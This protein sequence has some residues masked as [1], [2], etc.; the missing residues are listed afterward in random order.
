MVKAD[1]AQACV[2]KRSIV[3][4]DGGV[5]YASP[6][7]LFQVTGGGFRNLTE[8][9]FTR[10]EWQL[11]NP[12]SLQGFTVGNY[13][14]GFY[15]G[16]SG[17]M[18]DM[19]SMDFMPLNWYASAGYYDAKFDNLYLVTNNNQ[20]V[21]FDTGT[22]LTMTWRSKPFYS[23]K[24]CNMSVARVEAETYPVTANI[25]ADGLLKHT[26]SVLDRQPFRLPSGF[27]A[28][29]WS[30][31]VVG[32]VAIYSLGLATAVEELANG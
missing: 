19:G 8:S 1:I 21:T 14:L 29:T 20:L 17:F 28:N 3:D 6:D 12:A 15:N 18:L 23:P 32:A 31:E 25:Y 7:G 2:S 26:Q 9:L 10:I 24:A 11:L 27:L 13:Y 22:N 16:T 30:I 5:V 4:T